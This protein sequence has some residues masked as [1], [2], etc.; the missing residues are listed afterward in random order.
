MPE[1][2][3]SAMRRARGSTALLHLVRS[4]PIGGWAA[5]VPEIRRQV[6]ADEALW[7]V[8]NTVASVGNV[9]GLALVV[10]PAG[11]IRNE[12]FAPI[13]A[14]LVLLTVP[15]TAASTGLAATVV[16]LT[17][18]AFVAHLMDVPMGAMAL[19]VQRR[20]R[21]P[22]MGSFDACFAAGTL[23]G[24][25]L[26]T[27]AAATGVQPWVRLATTSAVLGLGLAVTVRWLPTEAFQVT[28]DLRSSARRRFNR[29]MLPIAAMAFLSGYVSESVVLWCALYVADTMAGGPVAGGIAYTCPV[30]AGAAT[31]LFVDRAT[32][33]VGM[34]RLV[35]MSTL[36]GVGGLGVCLL[37]DSPVAATAGFVILSIGVAAVNPSIYTPAGSRPELTTSE[38]V[39]VVE[40][41][42]MPG[43]AIA[44][45]ALIAALSSLAGLRVALGTVVVATAAL[46]LLISRSP[47]TGRPVAPRPHCT[48]GPQSGRFEVEAQRVNLREDE[49]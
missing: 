20:Y 19:A 7:S 16:G 30:T 32:V 33:R 35:R 41:A 15:I 31:L 13:G 47:G 24:A 2:G 22:I 1:T 44:A 48:G 43:A 12:T 27:L 29:T 21:R 5:R 42:Q 11:R 34:I 25:A 38:S 14:G 28:T 45:P 37:I 17:T 3:A 23:A 18:W 26:G 4:V 49:G 36:I 40:V 9:V 39:S 6:G 10:S 8:A 46:T